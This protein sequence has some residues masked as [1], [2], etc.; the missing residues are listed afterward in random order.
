MQLWPQLRELSLSGSELLQNEGE[1]AWT[2]VA[3]CMAHI[4]AHRFL[5]EGA[6]LPPKVHTVPDVVQVYA[7]QIK[8]CFNAFLTGPCSHGEPERPYLF[9]GFECAVLSTRHSKRLPTSENHMSQKAE[10]LRQ[11]CCGPKESNSWPSSPQATDFA[12][13]CGK[14]VRLLLVFD[15]PDISAEKY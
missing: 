8:Q 9:G 12:G 2:A 11:F 6:G 5:S 10:L 7:C 3:A 1:P 14:Q 15:S 13:S 4:N